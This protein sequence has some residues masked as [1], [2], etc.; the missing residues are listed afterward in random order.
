MTNEDDQPNPYGTITNENKAK[1]LKNLL[2]GLYTTLERQQKGA[3]KQVTVALELKTHS[4]GSGTFCRGCSHHGQ[5]DR[6]CC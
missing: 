5:G 1:K 4:E 3:D 6:K 2:N